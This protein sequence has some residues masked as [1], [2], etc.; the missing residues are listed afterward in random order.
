MKLDQK[1]LQ[2]LKHL[3]QDSKMTNKEISNKLKLSVTAV[4]ERIKRLEREGVISK[5]VALVSP[6][7]VE[8]NF[9]VFCQIKLIQHS[10]SYLTKFESEVTKLTEVLECY[11]VSGEYDYILKVIVKDMEAY[12]EFMVTKLTNLDHIGSTQSTFIISPV[13]STTAIPL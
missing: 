9:M 10:R 7:K 3:Q 6:D 4:F 12:R 1:D 11:H 2:I 5:Y 13:K 8:K